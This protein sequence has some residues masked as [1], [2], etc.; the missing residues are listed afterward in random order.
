[1]VRADRSFSVMSANGTL[2]SRSPGDA[3]GLPPDMLRFLA[4]SLKERAK[5]YRKR[6]R[7][8]QHKFS[9]KSVHDLRVSARRLLSLLDLLGPFLPAGRL[10]KLQCELKRHLDTFDDLRDTQVLVPTVREWRNEFPAARRFYRFL[11]QREGRLSRS[12]RKNARRLRRKPLG[13]L[14]QAVTGGLKDCL[15]N[16]GLG[17]TSRLVGHALGAAFSLAQSRKNRIDPADTHSIHCTRVAFK[18]FRYV[19]EALK[20]CCGVDEALLVKMHDYQTLMG[21]I[22]DAEVLLRAFQKF[23][24]KKRLDA[25]M[26]LEFEHILQDRRERRIAKYLARAEELLDFWPLPAATSG[27]K[28]GAAGQS[29]RVSRGGPGRPRP[30]K[31]PARKKPL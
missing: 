14:L 30:N 26:A 19:V 8:C 2:P 28:R 3:P 18:K 7:K 20:G 23:A 21:D 22:Q 10:K 1:M 11:E 27:Q 24:R 25:R 17:E 9:E 15:R 4:A 31:R 13:K 16:T 29:R 5:R 6:L 12:T